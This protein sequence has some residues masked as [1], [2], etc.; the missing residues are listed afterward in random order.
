[1]CPTV[2]EKRSLSVPCGVKA[3]SDKGNKSPRLVIGL[4]GNQLAGE[5]ASRIRELGWE[6]GIARAGEDAR[7]LAVRSKAQVLVL[8]LTEGNVLNTA[9]LVTALPKRTKVVLVGPAGNAGL[10]QASRYLGAAAFVGE[11]AGVQPLVE[12][13]LGAN[14]K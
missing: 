1:M 11:S 12:A 3:A 10:E 7:R 2:V 9:K 8:G 4:D 14:G 5:A 13:V 6:V